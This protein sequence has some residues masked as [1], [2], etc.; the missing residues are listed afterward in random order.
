MDMHMSN[1][2]HISSGGQRRSDAG[3]SAISGAIS[4]VYPSLNTPARSNRQSVI[5]YLGGGL[6]LASD[7]FDL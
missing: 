1:N 2:A 6:W 7:W 3:A 4:D 5:A